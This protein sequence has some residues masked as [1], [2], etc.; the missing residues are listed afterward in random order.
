VYIHVSVRVQLLCD[1]AFDSKCSASNSRI[2]NK[3]LRISL[4][5]K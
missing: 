1:L 5:I 4:F 3:V 2:S